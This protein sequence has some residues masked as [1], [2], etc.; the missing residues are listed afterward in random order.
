M[1]ML[2]YSRSMASYHRLVQSNGCGELIT[3]FQRCHRRKRWHGGVPSGDVEGR[4]VNPH[5]VESTRS[6]STGRVGEQRSI[7][8]VVVQRVGASWDVG[9]FHG[10][11]SLRLMA[12]Q[13]QFPLARYVLGIRDGVVHGHRLVQQVAVGEHGGVDGVTGVSSMGEYHP[14]M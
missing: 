10:W 5:P 14:E 6:G 12:V 9:D 2:I 8:M 7:V 3:T 13:L 1:F 11:V 4:G